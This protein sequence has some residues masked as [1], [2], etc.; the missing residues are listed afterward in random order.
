MPENVTLQ[1]D[2]KSYE[3]PVF[4]GTENEKAIDI[5]KLRDDTGYVTLDIGY[6]NTGATTSRITYLDG[7]IGNCWQ[8]TKAKLGSPH[9][10][11]CRSGIN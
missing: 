11:L 7:D 1:Y 5:A 3:M 8:A 2:G 9:L 10:H 4:T 6:K